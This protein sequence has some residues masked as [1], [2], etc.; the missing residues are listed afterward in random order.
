MLAGAWLKVYHKF[1]N[2]LSLRFSTL[3]VHWLEEYIHRCQAQDFTD[4]GIAKVS[5]D[6]VRGGHIS[7]FSRERLLTPSPDIVILVLGGNDLDE[8][9]SRGCLQPPRLIAKN[10][11]TLAKS[12]LKE[13]ASLLLMDRFLSMD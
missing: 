12:L 9:D 6:G 11:H 1:I 3:K 7:S 2:V 13:P 4:S 8:K 5:F 10:L